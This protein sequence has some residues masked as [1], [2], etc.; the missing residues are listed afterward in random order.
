MFIDFPAEIFAEGLC[1]GVGVAAPVHGYMVLETVEVKKIQEFLKL[2]HL[3]D[4][5]AAVT[6]ERVVRESALADVRLD[7][8]ECIVRAYPGAAK[9]V[10]YPAHRGE[11]IEVF[12]KNIVHN[13]TRMISRIHKR[14]AVLVQV[15]AQRKLAA[16]GIAPFA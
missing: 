2:R 15:V 1:H 10:D 3:A 14:Y 5:D 16:E 11:S 7:Y 9:T 13:V 8:T 12:S 4:S 6:L